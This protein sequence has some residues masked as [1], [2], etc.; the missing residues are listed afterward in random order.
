MK[1]FLVIIIALNCIG[2][3]TAQDK[4]N[5][6][7]V[8]TGSLYGDLA[9]VNSSYQL[10]QKLEMN[11]L[12]QEGKSPFLAGLLSAVVPGAGEFY[13]ESYLKAAIFAVVEAGLITAAIIY[14]NKGDEKTDEFENYADDSW[15]VVKYAEWM[16]NHPQ[17]NAQIEIDYSSP[18]LKPWQRIVDWEELNYWERQVNSLLGRGFSHTLHPYGEQQYYELIGKYDQYAPGWNDYSSG[19][20][21]EAKSPNF[22][23]YSGLRGDANDLYNIAGKA[24]IGIYINHFLSILDA[25]WTA[26]EFNKDLALKVRVEELR[27]ANTYEL[28]PTIKLSYNF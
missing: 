21:Y 28:V 9:S 16:N 20:N 26:T 24:V 3:L 8:L 4:Q 17:I 11:L 25:V 19:L 14:D 7:I 1:K 13:S 15:S 6:E 12:S 5:S 22:F 23:Y 10:P 18:N 2:Y 27:Y